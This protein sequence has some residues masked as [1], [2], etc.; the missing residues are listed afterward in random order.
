MTTISPLD[1]ATQEQL[2]LVDKTKKETETKEEVQQETA[3]NDGRLLYLQNEQSYLVDFVIK[4]YG[5]LPKLTLNQDEITT[6]EGQ[7]NEK[8]INETC[9]TDGF[10]EFLSIKTDQ[11]ARIVPSIQFYKQFFVDGKTDP[12]NDQEFVFKNY[13]DLSNIEQITSDRGFRG[14]ACGIKDV[15]IELDGKN[16][17]TGQMTS[18]SANFLFNDAQDIFSDTLL[19]SGRKISY[20]DLFSQ[21]INDDGTFFNIKLAVGWN[22]EEKV[23]TNLN[24]KFTKMILSLQLRSYSIELR[25]DGYT[26]LKI[27]YIGAIENMLYDPYA[28]NILKVSK[29]TKA[30]IKSY[31]SAKKSL[32]AERDRDTTGLYG[33]DQKAK[34]SAAERILKAEKSVEDIS[35]KLIQYKKVGWVGVVKKTSAELREEAETVRKSQID[36]SINDKQ[37]TISKIKLNEKIEGLR[38]IFNDSKKIYTVSITKEQLDSYVKSIEED[39]YSEGF[40]G[41]EAPKLNNEE[42][43]VKD[44][45]VAV[46]KENETK[47]IGFSK[48]T[49]TG[50]MLSEESSQKEIVGDLL[51]KKYISFIF[52]GDLLQMLFE[53]IK[54]DLMDKYNQ[55]IEVKLGEIIVSPPGLNEKVRMSIAKLPVSLLALNN[56]FVNKIIGKSNDVYTFGQFVEEIIKELFQIAL[57]QTGKTRAGYKSNNFDILSFPVYKT[58]NGYTTLNNGPI[59]KLCLF[60]YSS[61]KE[62]NDVSVDY[63]TNIKNKI[64]HFYFAGTDRGIV[65]SIKFLDNTNQKM[66]MGIYE[67]SK[68]TNTQNDTSKSDGIIQPKFYRVTIRTIG[69]TFFTIGQTIYL[70]TNVVGINNNAKGRNLYIG[71]AYFIFKV[72]HTL[73][74]DSFETTVEANF[75]TPEEGIRNHKFDTIK[76]V[77]EVS[78]Q[79]NTISYPDMEKSQA[80]PSKHFAPTWKG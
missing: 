71:G 63:L 22:G 24:L 26:L 50:T 19:D 2:D 3:T 42:Q 64:P 38:E 36:D 28:A 33:D 32:K 9:S 70:D 72:T 31:E 69:T 48:I 74:K 15:K 10:E 14:S 5:I 80:E 20:A 65:K 17:A 46:G 44:S 58:S 53:Y 41:T 61:T 18:V 60:F 30:T 47:Q 1:F 11:Q 77:D 27:E 59:Q 8:F 51:E 67:R 39:E 13:T 34:L 79:L 43:I 35:K 23:F 75:T 57:Q 68:Q 73:G 12:S 4:N 54:E 6:L 37:V 45:T 7:S 78:K 21:P 76:L 40:V 52:F 56:F 66:S 62:C 49:L 29:K 16:P 55:S 25:E